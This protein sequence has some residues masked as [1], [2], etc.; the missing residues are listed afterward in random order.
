MIQPRLRL[1]VPLIYVRLLLTVCRTVLAR[2]HEAHERQIEVE[3]GSVLIA[4][5]SSFGGAIVVLFILNGSISFG[6]DVLGVFLDRENRI[7]NERI[8]SDEVIGKS[9]TP[10]LLRFATVPLDH[11]KVTAGLFSVLVGV[12]FI[13]GPVLVKS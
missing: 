1:L 3:S 8:V 2:A 6:K 9:R 12:V 10:L 11:T 7:G 5:L 4:W 13:A